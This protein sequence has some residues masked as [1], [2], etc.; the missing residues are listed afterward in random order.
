MLAF[1]FADYINLSSIIFKYGLMVNAS[2]RR[3]SIK[4]FKSL[5]DCE[6][7]IKELNVIVGTNASG[8]S[9]LVEVF[10]LLKKI[11]VDK[12][13]NPF[14]EWW[15]YDNVVWGKNEELP[16]TIELDFDIDGYDVYFETTFTGVGGSF[17]IL[18]EILDVKG[19][20]KFEKEGEWV[21]VNHNK[22]FIEGLIKNIS[23]Y[24]VAHGFKIAIKKNKQK[25]IQNKFQ[26][27]NNQ[28]LLEYND[29]KRVVTSGLH[30]GMFIE[31]NTNR[32]LM[33]SYFVVRKNIKNERV[34]TF[35]PAIGEGYYEPI[36]KI[37]FDRLFS[38]TKNVSILYPLNIRSMKKPQPFKRE[39]KLKEDGSNI[40]NVFHSIYL[41]EGKIPDDIYNPLSIIFPNT[42]V[43]PYITE[44]GRVFIRVYEDGVEFNPPNVSDGL[45][46]ILTILT[47]I[48]LKPSLLI[49]DE[50]ENSLHPETLELV[51]DT[52]K[53]SE[54][55]TII[56]THS[57][58]MVDMTKP[59]DIILIEKEQ[60][61]S[62][63]KR[64]E[65]P[66]KIRKFLNKKQIT[67]SEGWIYGDLFKTEQKI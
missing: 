34:N 65:D 6:I 56:T 35:C 61:E 50:L 46:K 30:Q 38:F 44:D 60:G 57:P 11:Y 7:D 59:D 3:V 51:L 22:I 1:D 15:G 45:Y 37:A 13:I 12:D 52:I 28:N 54:V 26:L 39:E 33:L 41:K 27:I 23:K 66:E 55:R 48:H 19:Y 49:V 14:S 42:E 18:R 17:Q 9:N 43:R 24:E 62:K 67:F 8:K 16:V 25:L 32:K 36:Y 31:K 2:L 47:A 40:A 5:H 29:I 21:T 64:P 20:V 58:I 53:T 10:R 4:N 63:F